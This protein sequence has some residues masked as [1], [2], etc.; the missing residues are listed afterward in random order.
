MRRVLQGLLLLASA[1][2]AAQ[3]RVTLRGSITG[4]SAAIPFA[5]VE[6]DHGSRVFTD[7]RG[8]FVMP[9]L[10]RGAHALRV[11]QV[12]Y[13]PADTTISMDA[14][15]H[16]S[17]TLRHL[18]MRL[19][20][21]AVTAGA[22]A[23]TETGDDALAI[24]FGQVLENARRLQLLADEYPFVYRMQRAATEIGPNEETVWQGIDTVALKSD[25]RW[26]YVPGGLFRQGLGP[27]GRPARVVRVPQL[28]DFA[29]SAF[30][31]RHCFRYAGVTQLD[32]RPSLLVEFTVRP[33]VPSFDV[34]GSV[35]LDAGT[36]QVR[37]IAVRVVPEDALPDVSGI[38]MMTDFREM[39]PHIVLPRRI[40]TVTR[41]RG[42]RR[43]PGGRQEEEQRLLGVHFLRP[44]DP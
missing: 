9:G 12:G 4:D 21:I 13:E 1:P 37:R 3:E 14:D 34:A 44:L 30:R 29:D 27:R 36:Y 39:Q 38:E 24:I 18:P 7:A 32:G 42:G 8:A 2:L 26:R 15:L 41:T 20:A 28:A 43:A 5:V 25:E 11:R 10:A 40:L 35:W 6:I 31:E 19:R 22:C 23:A 16:V 33:A 17:I